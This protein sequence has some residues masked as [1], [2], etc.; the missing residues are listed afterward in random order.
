MPEGSVRSESTAP[1]G[2]RPAEGQ[3]NGG[4]M[5]RVVTGVDDQ[6]RSTV[7]ED[8]PP[9]VAF[10]AS[11]DAPTSLGRTEGSGVAPGRAIVHQIWLNG[12]L[13]ASGTPDPTLGLE[14][15]D[16]DTPAGATSWIVTEMGPNLEPY[17]HHTATVD[18][19][20]VIRGEV[21][22]ILETGSVVLRAGDAVYVDGVEHA[23]RTGAEGCVI[24]TVQ[25]GLRPEDR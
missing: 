9:P 10:G 16:F 2:E 4:A 22:L 21:E 1:A 20:I 5:R 19:G 23:W 18:Y 3:R 15:P 25:V 8:G 14:A 11:P 7:L 12:P 6:G 17:M 13:P 24:A